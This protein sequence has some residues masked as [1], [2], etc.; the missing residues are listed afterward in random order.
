MASI[1]G[2]EPEATRTR[3]FQII[4]KMISAETLKWN[5]EI[6]G[7]HRIGGLVAG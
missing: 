3:V 1:I 4:E 5:G 2:P 7:Y 6:K